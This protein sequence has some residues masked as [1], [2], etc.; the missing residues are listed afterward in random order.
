MGDEAGLRG[1]L[2]YSQVI[3]VVFVDTKPL[4]NF[5]L[6]LAVNSMHI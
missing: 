4:C 3:M 6:F 2:S 5:I 1:S